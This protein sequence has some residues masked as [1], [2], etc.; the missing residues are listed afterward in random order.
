MT[1][2]FP[3]MLAL[4]LMSGTSLDGIDAALI[5]TD[6]VSVQSFG[7]SFT[8]PYDSAS[9]DRLRACLG[10]RESPAYIKAV[11]AE[12]TDHHA[13]A[14]R[15]LLARAGVPL[16]DVGVIGFH[17]Q[18]IAHRPED[19]YT[20][21]IG[22]GRMLARS[23]GVPVVFDM[24][25]ADVAAGGQ[26]APLASTLHRALA[27]DLDGPTAILNVG[28]VA[29]VT[30]LPGGDGE[31]LA[32][33]T[34][35][36]NALMDDWMQRHTG[37]ICDTGGRV[38]ARGTVDAAALTAMMQHP[39]F[40]EVPPKSLDRDD[41]ATLA[42]AVAGLSLEDGAA[43]LAAFTVEAAAVAAR[44][45][46]APAKRWLVCGGGRH[47]PTLMSG[48]AARLGLPVEP[49]EVVGWDG[50]ALEAQAFAFLAVRS[51]RGLPLTFPGTTGVPVALTGGCLA[52][53]SV[54]A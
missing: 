16:A 24:R 30:W 37:D 42:R 14:V 41:F 10:E 8:M 33:D 9:R 13:H 2:P 36:G 11:E 17:G 34:G 12:L 47:N 18:T 19:R 21:Q 40:A 22:D 15:E 3:T 6:G 46:P 49:V 4:G 44:W 52:R 31:P 35:P 20:R 29:N 50:D 54:A 7:A 48:L 23:L 32:F 45:F 1:Q 53:P 43:T 26:G 38:A 39:Y 5:S 51:L 28:G 25:S 27:R